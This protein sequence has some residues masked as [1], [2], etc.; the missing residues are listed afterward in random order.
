M[1]TNRFF[2][3][4]ALTAAILA[5]AGCKKDEPVKKITFPEAQTLQISIDETLP[6]VFE[7]DADW[8]L[9]IDKQWLVFVDGEAQVSQISG[10]AGPVSLTLTTADVTSIFDE[11]TA[12]IDITMGT[13]TQTLCTVKRLAAERTAAMWSLPWSGEGEEIT[14]LDFK[15]EWG[16]VSTAKVTFSA[17]FDWVVKSIPDWMEGE[18]FSGAAGDC[19]NQNYQYFGVKEEAYPYEKTGDIVISDQSGE[20]EITFPATFTGMGDED[21]L[22]RDGAKDVWSIAFSANHFVMAMGPSGMEESDRT[23]MDLT[24]MTKNLEYS[25]M[26]L[27]QKDQWGM[28]QMMWFKDPWQLEVNTDT[29]G[30]VK[31]SVTPDMAEAFEGY[32]LIVPKALCPAN[33]DEFDQFW[34][35]ENAS[36]FENSDY[37]I[38][39]TVDAPAATAGGF[40]LSWTRTLA[41]GE[42]VPFTSY[43]GFGGMKPSDFQ[44]G[45]PDDNTYVYELPSEI[46]GPL[47]MLPMGFPSNWQAGVYNGDTITYF[48]RASGEGFSTDKSNFDVAANIYDSNWQSHM[49]LSYSEE[50]MKAAP[51]MSFL[52]ISFYQDMSELEMYKP[53]AALVLVKM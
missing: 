51:S 9:T 36:K 50:A 6:L 17:N 44:Y 10:V 15:Y 11:E 21:I 23:S 53:S 16:T 47:A 29:P 42:A 20:H 35:R 18:L 24:I 49:A 45:L 28:G 39:V 33:P 31:V 32:I 52:I 1:K 13:E 2:A 25:V 12:T 41:K 48:Y 26:V 38:K 5:S 27:E 40:M 34:F 19:D 22:V 8:K 30:T 14:S 4:L 43:E 46:V 3:V 37:M 7:A